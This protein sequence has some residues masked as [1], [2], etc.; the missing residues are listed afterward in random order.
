MEQ[1][2]ITQMNTAVITKIPRY[3]SNRHQHTLEEHIRL[4]AFWMEPVWG[5]SASICIKG[6]TALLVQGLFKCDIYKVQPG[7]LYLKAS[8][9][10][11]SWAIII[12]E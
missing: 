8:K 1:Y 4:D 12:N 2:V 3:V 5:E 10:I 7:C 11:S 9:Y 6:L